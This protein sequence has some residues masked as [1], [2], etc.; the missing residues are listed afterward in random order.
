MT[1]ALKPEQL[2][3]TLEEA[4]EVCRAVDWDARAELTELER[5]AIVNVTSRYM[6]G[7]I[8]RERCADILHI[9]PHELPAQWQHNIR[10]CR[11]CGGQITL[12]DAHER[13]VIEMT[14]GK[15]TKD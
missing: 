3:L 9:H 6:L 8:S 7:E 15:A 1:D 12:A 13:C 10:T 2:A 14:F 4:E 11:H 5:T